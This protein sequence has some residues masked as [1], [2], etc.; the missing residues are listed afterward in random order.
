MSDMFK[1]ARELHHS[2]ELQAAEALYRQHLEQEPDDFKAHCNLGCLLEEQGR[3]VEAQKCQ[4]TACRIKPDE[5][6]PHYNLGHVLQRQ[7]RLEAAADAYRRALELAPGYMAAHFNLGKLLHDQGQVEDAVTSLQRAAECDPESF[8]AHVELGAVL[9]GLKRVD[10]AVVAYQR[11]LEVN[12]EADEQHYFLGRMLETLGRFPEAEAAYRRTLELRPVSVV[13]MEALASLV[14]KMGK[15]DEAI[16]VLEAWL[17]MMPDEPRAVHLLAALSGDAVPERAADSYVATVFDQFSADF[18]ETLERLDYRAPQLVQQALAREYPQMDG[19]LRILD[20]GCGTGLCGPL[21]TPY[22]KRLVGVDLSE[23]M[24]EKARNRGGY[25]ELVCEEL[26]RYLERSPAD[27][28]VIVS[29]DT[30]NYFGDLAAVFA[31]ARQALRAGG[32]FIFTLEHTQADGDEPGYILNPHGR[33]SH[34]ESYVSETLVAAGFSISGMVGG[35]L[36]TEEGQPVMGL[37]I[38]AIRVPDE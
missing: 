35:V 11:A 36:R 22:A 27:F 23:G 28:D 38:T 17:Q 6:I 30:L 26:T 10:E 32:R 14:H 8:E 21:L 2:G 7:N 9:F 29:A 1:Q 33:Y 31:A 4:M 13:T 37:V 12:P 25:D 3:L 19:S 34:T 24:L 16:E 15:Q 5:Y 20:A 18:D